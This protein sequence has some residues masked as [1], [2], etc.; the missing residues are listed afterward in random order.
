MSYVEGFEDAIDLC[1]FEVRQAKTKEK[2]IEVI[3]EFAKVVYFDKICRLKGM[4][5]QIKK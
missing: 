4:L 5:K 2:A 3:G 1:L